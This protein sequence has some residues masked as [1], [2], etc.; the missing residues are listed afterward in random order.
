MASVLGMTE[1][2]A[3]S[4]IRNYQQAYPDVAKWQDDATKRGESG[5]ITNDWGRTMQ[6]ER[7]RSFTQS[8]AL[9]GQSGTASILV[10]GL[11]RMLRYDIRLIQWLAATVHDAIVMD[12]PDEH[13]EWAVPKIKELMECWWGPSDGT[14]Q[15]IHFPVSSGQPADDWMQAGH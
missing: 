12:I 11:I 2:E 13:L 6:V 1:A 8:S 3:L 10:D 15:V 14:G 5:Q 7:D 4:F 9:L